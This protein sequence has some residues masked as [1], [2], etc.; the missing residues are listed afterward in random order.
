ML[1]Y[2]RIWRQKIDIKNSIENKCIYKFEIDIST[3]TQN[4]KCIEMIFLTCIL[5]RI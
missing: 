1:G 3:M 4:P 2:N 5:R